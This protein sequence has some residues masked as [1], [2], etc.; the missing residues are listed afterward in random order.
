MLL[1]ELEKLAAANELVSIERNCHDEE[2]TG[3]LCHV[4]DSLI[5]MHLF[6]SAG[7][8]EGFAVFEFDQVEE[9]FWG[10]REHRAIRL[11][12][13]ARGAPQN[14]NLESTDFASAID[15]LNR[16]YASL[17]LHSS[18]DED[19]YEIAHIEERDDNWCKIQTFSPMKS[20]SRT[21]KMIKTDLI[22]RVVVN[23]PYQIDI[24]NLHD[25]EL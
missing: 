5:T 18:N 4:S 13:D 14:V 22:T 21:Y 2:L 23:S 20:L 7:D 10:N 3:L 9:M 12:V 25:S 8:Y 16:S 1:Q 11:L 6:A 15:E 17:C 24:V 19:H